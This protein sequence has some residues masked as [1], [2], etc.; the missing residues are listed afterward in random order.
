MAKGNGILSARNPVKLVFYH[1]SSTRS[2]QR[3]EEAEPPTDARPITLYLRKTMIVG[4]E[5]PSAIVLTVSV[6]K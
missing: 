4:E 3:Y 6:A 2:M 1:H 5:A